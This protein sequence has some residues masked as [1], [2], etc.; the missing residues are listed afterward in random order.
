MRNPAC[1]V[2]NMFDRSLLRLNET[3]QKLYSA[4]SPV[5]KTRFHVTAENGNCAALTCVHDSMHAVVLDLL[6]KQASAGNISCSCTWDD[7]DG[8]SFLHVLFKRAVTRHFQ[9]E[10]STV[11]EVFHISDIEFVL[12]RA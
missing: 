11:R 3:D 6:D 10:D 4:D 5:V 12:G 8:G 7:E 2:T 9:G 1:E